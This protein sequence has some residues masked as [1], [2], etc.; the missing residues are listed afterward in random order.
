MA[1]VGMRD[2]LFDHIKQIMPIE[3]EPQ[4]IEVPSDLRVV[5]VQPEL[6]SRWTY[7]CEDC[8]KTML[9]VS[10]R[11][12]LIAD[13]IDTL[14]NQFISVSSLSESAT[15]RLKGRT[16]GAWKVRRVKYADAPAV[17]AELRPRYARLVIACIKPSVWK[18]TRSE[19]CKKVESDCQTSVKQVTI[20][21]TSK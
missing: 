16:A 6:W 20:V 15:C 2:F 21:S 1:F 9:I 4:L 14:C 10:Q 7:V 8:R 13:A 17:L 19:M 12:H 18:M 3:V 5:E 11:L